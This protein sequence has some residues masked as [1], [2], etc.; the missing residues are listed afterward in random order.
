M[1]E[2][3]LAMVRTISPSFTRK[4]IFVTPR[5]FQKNRIIKVIKK[6]IIGNLPKAAG[7]GRS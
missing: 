3:R 6:E 4:I 2:R 1:G 7:G 5:G